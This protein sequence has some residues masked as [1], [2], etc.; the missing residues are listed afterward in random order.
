MATIER[1]YI[2]THIE[3]R[4]KN[5]NG[6]PAKIGGIAAMVNTVTDMGWYEEKIESGAFN[7]VLEKSDIRCLF[8]HEDELILGR[9]KSGTLRVNIDENGNLAYECDIDPLSPTHVSAAR[10]IERGDVDQSS[11]QFVARTTEWT[12][13]EK[14]GEMGMRVIKEFEALYDVSPVTFPAYQ[15]TVV[16]ARKVVEA[17][18]A[19]KTERDRQVRDAAEF[20][21]EQLK[22]Y[23]M[24]IIK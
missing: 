5:E 19:E 14:Y 20:E 4:A 8:N 15:E 3:I 16:E 18:D 24:N 9:V 13:S 21:T 1:R 2:P 17:R 12:Y 7:S 23:Y 6:I 11:F 10:A 22:F